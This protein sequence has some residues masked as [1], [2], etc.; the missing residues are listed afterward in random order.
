LR[1]DELDPAVIADADLLH[2]TGISLGLSPSLAEVVLEAV[3]I[4]KTA[5]TLVSFD[6]N[7]RS[8]LWSRD[9]ATVAYRQLI[10][11]VDIV[12]GG[13]DEAA[14]AVGAAPSPGVLARRLVDLGASEAV[15]K[16]GRG[17]AVAVA[18]GREYKRAAVPIVPLDTVGAGD[19]F[20]AGYIAD[21]L[22]D[23]PTET[24]LTTAVTAGAYACLVSGDW[25]GSP[26]REELAL[27][28]ASE[29]VRR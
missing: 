16:L 28:N 3:R 13:D 27:L 25:E 21:R 26:R 4:A 19:A 11:L 2:V 7:F 5:G 17:G 14:L 9:E 10:P 12:F 24:C 20:V 22:L 1:W 6:L 8:K 23:Q 18:H 15:V 29:P